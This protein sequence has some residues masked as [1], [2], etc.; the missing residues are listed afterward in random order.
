MLRDDIM[1]LMQDPTGQVNADA[2]STAQFFSKVCAA[3]T[4]SAGP[5]KDGSTYAPLCEL[6]GEASGVTSPCAGNQEVNPYYDYTGA[7]RCMD[8]ESG[9]V[10]FVKHTTLDDF[11]QENG[12]DKPAGDYKILCDSGCRD[13]KQE[14]WLRD[15]CKTGESASNAVVAKAGF[16]DGNALAAAAIKSLLNGG[17]GNAPKVA[18][19]AIN[20]NKNFFWG[21]STDKI[22]NVEGQTFNNQFF[23]AY[24]NFREIRNSDMTTVRVCI[25]KGTKESCQNA[26]MRAYGSSSL[27]FEC[28]KVTDNAD[29][30]CLQ[31]VKNQEADVTIVGGNELFAANDQYS[32]AAIVAESTGAELGDASY[33]GVALTKRD[34][35]QTVDGANV[36]GSITGLNSNLK[37]MKACHTG[38]RKTSGWY[39]PVGKLSNKADGIDFDQWAEEAR[40]EGVRVDAEAVEKFWDDNVCAP[41]TTA[42]GP[43]VGPNGQGQI[44]DGGDGNGG[45]CKLCKGDCSGETES[46]PYAGYAGALYCMDEKNAGG[47]IAF[48]KH[49][50]PVDYP[51]IKKANQ[52]PLT[53]ANDL[54][55]YVGI[56]DTG[57]KTLYN[58]G[59]SYVMEN[60]RPAYETCNTGKSAS[61]AMVARKEFV[62]TTAYTTL[63]AAMGLSSAQSAAI[64]AGGEITN[65]EVNNLI[66]EG[67][68]GLWSAD[69]ERLYRLANPKTGFKDF[70][71]AYDSFKEIRDSDLADGEEVKVCVPSTSDELVEACSSVMNAQYGGTYE[72]KA[73][74]F[75]CYKGDSDENC[76]RRISEGTDHITTFGGDELFL[77]HE[78]Y[79]L[80]ALVAESY[81]DRSTATYF[82]LAVVKSDKC[83]DGTFT[84]FNKA[85]LQDKKACHT[86]YRKTAG[87]VL[88]VG[89][90]LQGDDPIMPTVSDPDGQV[91]TDAYSASQFFSRMCAPRTTSNGPSKGGS[92][93]APLCDLCQEA[94]GVVNSC[95]GNQDENPYYDY[96][97][98]FR[99]MDEGAG[100]VA[101][102]KHTTIDDFNA[103]LGT[104]KVK[105]DYQILCDN[106][107]ANWDVYRTDSTCITG[108]SASKAVVTTQA[109]KE[110]DLGKAAR[111]SLGNFKAAAKE[112]NGEEEFF[113]SASTSSII[114]VADQEFKG[115]FFQAYSNFQAIRAADALDAGEIR[116][117]I[118]S[119]SAESCA[120][121]L[122]NAY[123]GA[124]NNIRFSCSLANSDAECLSNVESGQQDVT[125]VG[126]NE[127]F[128]AN[129]AHDLVAYVAEV[130]DP[131][132][133][134]ANYYG[135]AVIKT[136]ACTAGAAFN[137]E[138]LQGLVACSTGYRKTSGWVLPVGKML[139]DDN[140]MAQRADPDG[141]INGDAFSFAKFFR[142][143]VCAPRVVADGPIKGGKK[144]DELCV[145]CAGDCSAEDPYAGYGGALKCMRDNGNSR[146]AFVK[147]TTADDEGLTQEEKSELRLLC[148]DGCREWTADNAKSSACS[149]GKSASNA[150]V[151]R[152]DFDATKKSNLLSAMGLGGTETANVDARMSNA[153]KSALVNE[154]QTGFWS[155]ETKQLKRLTA[156]DAGFRD[157]F[158]AYDQ[159]EAIRAFEE[160]KD[161]EDSSDIAVRLSG[162]P[163]DVL[164]AKDSNSL[165]ERQRYNAWVGGFEDELEKQ[166]EEECGCE[167]TVTVLEVTPVNRRRSLLATS[168]DIRSRAS[169]S[170]ADNSKKVTD[171]INSSKKFSIG[172]EEYTAS[173][174][175]ASRAETTVETPSSPRVVEKTEGM[176]DGGVAGIAVG[177]FFAGVFL[178]LIVWFIVYKSKG[179]R[180]L[181]DC[182][183]Q[184]QGSFQRMEEMKYNE[185]NNPTSSTAAPLNG[186]GRV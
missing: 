177:L 148:A 85:S 95:A 33:Y 60:G 1:P 120:T 184:S 181:P 131:Q 159:F 44:Y 30:E 76:M 4:V 31:K 41:G 14:S 82:G 155:A 80:E 101:F 10:A 123:G 167:V 7:F 24:E 158:S 163:E 54:S 144:Y 12:L 178:T 168:A 36:G 110:S 86:G 46:E 175:K 140:I 180:G 132:I 162:L 5:S 106:K 23:Q 119:G 151:G 83:T 2:Y 107:C 125:V 172:E 8:D 118:S 169:G 137:K 64:N 97:G 173:D 135:V 111:A 15:E 28:V 26:L 150:L 51:S 63:L 94:S 53:S 75:K 138:T 183:Q 18:A 39:L 43:K 170:S 22:V 3:R 164:A 90:M 58:P 71:T 136:Q 129:A 74:S 70:F 50:T 62:D 114:D 89:K 42:N 20:G 69:T 186:N 166:L 153:E 35:C 37:G 116:V 182:V 25:S 61:N 143:G 154:A 146:L 88:P 100:D 32:L 59:G 17:N 11:N 87:W 113:W 179:G 40:E 96:T 9:D 65:S 52:D 103:Q 174:A 152:K 105:A 128:L 141:E 19:K 147:H 68:T 165:S 66:D 130:V 171:E 124:A 56:C 45:L 21:M 176:H 126:G 27:R 47:D 185:Y 67:R 29:E 81:D 99:C 48:V 112:I 145:A 91:N 72:G 115:E 121:A 160:F 34:K 49:S 92:S 149:T 104:D 78:Q 84:G 102:V 156:T 127:L 77:S 16:T 13:Y 161:P 79:G 98:A 122:N 133:D 134:D 6:C 55:Q 38:Y 139:D 57:C 73:I 117:C 142:K 93:Y 108:E 157:F 109:F